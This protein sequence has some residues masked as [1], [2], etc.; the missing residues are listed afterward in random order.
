VR[1][2]P[3][4]LLPLLRPPP[5]LHT[6]LP[7]KRLPR[8][9]V[10]PPR[11]RR[12]A[13]GDL[14]FAARRVIG[15]YGTHVVPFQKGEVSRRANPRTWSGHGDKPKA[16]RERRDDGL[17]SRRCFRPDEPPRARKRGPARWKGM[18][19][20]D[21]ESLD[22][23][24]PNPGLL[25]LPDCSLRSLP[26]KCG[27]SH[28]TIKFVLRKQEDWTPSQRARSTVTDS[29]QF[30]LPGPRGETLRPFALTLRPTPRHRRVQSQAVVKR[31]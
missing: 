18:T 17:L 4:S 20:A 5:F 26:A 28:E 23:A 9:S 11:H 22:P 19:V 25:L 6:R 29:V 10:R 12:C 14:G 21:S 31:R 2:L 24:P 27:V 3:Q 30:L 16:W 15:P 1:W 13:L 7:G 8:R